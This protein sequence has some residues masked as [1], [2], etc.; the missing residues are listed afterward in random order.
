MLLKD[1]TLLLSL[2]IE[3]DELMS[4]FEQEIIQAAGLNFPKCLMVIAALI[5]GRLFGEKYSTCGGKGLQKGR[6]PMKTIDA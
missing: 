3:P 4:D 1:T 2:T 6:T 5:L